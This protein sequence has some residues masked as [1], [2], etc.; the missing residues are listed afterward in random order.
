[1]TNI[2]F[3]QAHVDFG[4]EL[5][6]RRLA[7]RVADVCF[8][9]GEFISEGTGIGDEVPAVRLNFEP[10][11]LR[12]ILGGAPDVG[13]TLEVEST[14]AFGGKL[15]V[16]PECVDSIADLSAYFSGLLARMS[17]VKIA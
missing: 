12:V 5:T 10:L 14:E 16:V 1:M 9:G 2:V 8:G 3:I 15:A 13:F 4:S 6:L 7:P 17:E 11:G